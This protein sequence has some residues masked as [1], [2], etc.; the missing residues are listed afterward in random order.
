MIPTYPLKQIVE[1]KQKRVEEAERVVKQ[2]Q[3]ALAT[4]EKKLKEREEER[5]KVKT[6]KAAKLKQ[7]RDC[8]D[9]GTTSPK[10]QQMKNYLKVVDEKLLIE[11]KK[12]A[13]QKN[14]VTIAEKNLEMARTDLLLKRREVDKLMQHK[15]DW[16]KQMKREALITE[17]KEQD[18]LGSMIYLSRHH[19]EG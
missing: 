8:L 6:H 2:K 14:N 12:V 17:G 5:D 16:E 3:E 1:V 9:A 15:Q 18:E 4:E 11:E 7:L 13:D 19:R 10:I